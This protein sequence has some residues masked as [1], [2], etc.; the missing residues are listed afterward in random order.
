M[1]K[2]V[3]FF[4][5]LYVCTPVDGLVSCVRFLAELKNS[6]NVISLS[7]WLE[8]Y[9]NKNCARF[10]RVRALYYPPPVSKFK[11]DDNIS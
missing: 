4:I 11:F 6:L 2:I 9:I 7:Y 10:S 5:H 1:T 8:I 3:G